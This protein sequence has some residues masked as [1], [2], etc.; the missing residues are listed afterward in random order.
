M[1]TSTRSDFSAIVSDNDSNAQDSYSLYRLDT[2]LQSA[3]TV[4]ERLVADETPAAP[5]ES[6]MMKEAE[7]QSW[8]YDFDRAAESRH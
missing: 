4:T 3:P 5:W 7:L 1:S 8:Q 6:I 2:F